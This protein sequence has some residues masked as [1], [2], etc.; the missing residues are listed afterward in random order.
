MRIVIAP[1]KFKGSL[2]AANAARAI[3]RGVHS[4]LPDALTA[5]CPMADGGEGTVAAMVAATGGR[6]IDAHV[7]GPLPGMKVNAQY[8]LLG[9]G[10]TAVIEMA[11][12]SGLA[13]LPDSQRNPMHTTTFGAGELIRAASNLG[14]HRI[15]LGIG[16][17]ATTDA[18]IGAL[19]A[20]GMQVLLDGNKPLDRPFVGSDLSRVHS[21]L[22]PSDWQLPEIVIACD[23]ENPL[24]GP[25]GAARVFGPQKGAC[26]DD[27]DKLDQWLHALVCRTHTDAVAN[28]KGAGAAGGLGYGFCAFVPG[29]RMTNGYA[30]IA[31]ACGLAQKLKDADLCFTAE[32][33][34]DDSSLKGKT[35]IGVA[36]DCRVRNIPCIILAGSVTREAEQ[37]LRDQVG[38]VAFCII[39]GPVTLPEAMSRTTELLERATARLVVV[40]NQTPGQTATISHTIAKS[41]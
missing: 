34:L 32:G 17:S 19:Q 25:E 6:L 30:L 37:M 1:D 11:A 20:L 4:A 28:M 7:T 27:V 3:E 21:L 2:S 14:I 16:G 22:P 31:E 40:L 38:S 9:D 13:L 35:A 5:L 24:C 39:D 26:P 15:I 41:Q 29:A 23:V 36:R 10:T 8:G 33:R 12:A 18:G